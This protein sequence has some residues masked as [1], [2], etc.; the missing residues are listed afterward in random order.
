MHFCFHVNVFARPLQVAVADPIELR[1]VCITPLR[2]P[3]TFDAFFP[4]PFDDALAALA[5]LPRLDAEP[6][7]FFVIAGGQGASHWCVSGHMFDFAGRLHR[8]ELHGDCP[9][10]SFDSLLA[11]FGGVA[12]PLVFELVQ[13]GVALDAASFRVWASRVVSDPGAPGAC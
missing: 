6:D 11:C 4:V 10:E 3:L 7:G 8:V 5:K 1:G 2:G 13:E 9:V 12:T